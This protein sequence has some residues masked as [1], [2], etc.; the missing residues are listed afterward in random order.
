MFSFGAMLATVA[1]MGGV[2][3]YFINRLGGEVKGATKETGERILLAASVHD[4]FT[5]L[6]SLERGIAVRAA[7]S[8]WSVTEKY[9]SDFENAAER[10]RATLQALRA[11]VGT[12]DG[13]RSIS[14]MDSGLEQWRELHGQFM[15]DV[16]DKKDLPSLAAFISGRLLPI[17]RETE[18]VAAEFLQRQRGLLKEAAARGDSDSGMAQTAVAVI[19]AFALILSGGVLRIVTLS[20]RELRQITTALATGASQVASASGQISSTSQSLAQG[21]NEQASS[22]EETGAASE[23]VNATAQRNSENARRTSTATA[24]AKARTSEATT[25][26]QEMVGAMNGINTSSEKI[27]RIIKVIDEIAFQTNILAL[28]ASVEAARAG[29][30]GM[31]FAVVADEVRNLAQRCAQAARDTSG[32]IE[33]SINRAADGKEK[34][35]RLGHSVLAINESSSQVNMLSDEVLMGSQE[36]AKGMQQI[37]QAITQMQ[38]VT[39]QSAASA[40]EGAAAGQELSAQAT[41]LNQIAAQLR[42]LV[43]ADEEARVA[44]PGVAFGARA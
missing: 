24:E 5:E 6:L 39:Q 43:G 36:Q 44:G 38:Q 25:V 18:G 3:L 30:A 13:R 37:S 40:E 20:S 28:N 27:S 16:R 33:E 17:S 12:E 1:V 4:Q 32:L 10:A 7:T 9:S 19:L 14:K 31:G 26:L 29:E 2:T 23:Q 11:V 15:R 35:E 34:L 42:D 21:A 41:H 8:D 22:L